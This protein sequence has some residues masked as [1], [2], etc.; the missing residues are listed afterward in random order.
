[1]AN[2][3]ILVLIVDP[4]AI[5]LVI[6]FNNIGKDP[7][8]TIETNSS[9]IKT[10]HI[11]QKVNDL[12]K[13]GKLPDNTHDTDEPTALANSQYRDDYEVTKDADWVQPFKTRKLGKWKPVHD[14]INSESN[15]ENTDGKSD[16]DLLNE[17]EADDY[18]N[19]TPDVE[20][21]NT[22]DVESNHTSVV[23]TDVDSSTLA[24][25]R[26][27]ELMQINSNNPTEFYGEQNKTKRIG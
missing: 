21:N 15:N 25:K 1:M 9:E 18:S 19:N 8:N 27:D 14:E 20:S 4:L 12:R 3:L 11:W 26:Y 22:P 24:K 10:D 2:W 16:L 7:T 17:F 5:V 13:E 6:V 23:D